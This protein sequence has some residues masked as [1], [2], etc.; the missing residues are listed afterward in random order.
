MSWLLALGFLGL[1]SLIPLIIIYIIKPNY[2]KKY[3]S[4][5]YVWKLAL[6]YRRRR[7]PI[8]K[9]RNILIFLCQ[10]LILCIGTFILIQPIAAASFAPDTAHQIIIIESSAGMRARCS[11]ENITRF[12]RAVYAARAEAGM[13]IA[14]GGVVH[15]II[16]GAEAKALEGGVITNAT[17]LNEALDYLIR[18]TAIENLPFARADAD[19]AIELAENLLAHSAGG[20]IVFFTSVDY[21]LHEGVDIR[22]VSNN[23]WNVAILDVVPIIYE[24]LYTFRVELASFGRNAPVPLTVTVYGANMIAIPD[25]ARF[26]FTETISLIDGIVEVVYFSAF[27]ANADIRIFS[28]THVQISVDAD[29]D[30]PYDNVFFLTEGTTETITLLYITPF[31]NPFMT[32][33]L[34]AF[35]TMVRSR[36]NLVIAQ[37]SLGSNPNAALPSADIYIF[38]HQMPAILPDDGLVM[39]FNPGASG[40]TLH[41]NLIVHPNGL[42]IE[43]GQTVQTPASDMIMLQS[44][45]VHHAV[46]NHLQLE[47]IGITMYTQMSP[48]EDFNT[49][50]YTQIGH[51]IISIK[52]EIDRKIV[53]I[54]FNIHRS[55]LAMNFIDF[56]LL[57]SNLF[58]YFVPSTF[59]TNVFNVGE[60]IS[61]NARGPELSVLGAGFNDVLDSFPA[62]ITASTWGLHTTSQRML[63]RS[64]DSVN[65]FFVRVAREESDFSRV[66]ASI[67]NPTIRTATVPFNRDLII[68]FAIALLVLIIL[69]RLLQLGN[70]N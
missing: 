26:S 48:S 25:Q 49:I 40:T 69:E 70:T 64:T 62:T 45:Q 28:Y 14:N 42:D 43:F 17:Q 51:P 37:T 31:P 13:T 15:I 12:E 27:G 39:L 53:V 9:F 41:P 2:Q 46:L 29:D 57:F 36:W 5:T 32:A 8:N 1:L 18:P 3:L 20:T 61:L 50:A 34:G 33:V 54:P 38:E 23:E 59:L 56:N 67:F 6:K 44:A 16:A 10:V 60:Q 30:F 11:E 52:N 66:E 7:L 55:T 21:L 24:N 63:G 22:N 19:G 65:L 47:N 35:Q 68:F 4:S 58:D